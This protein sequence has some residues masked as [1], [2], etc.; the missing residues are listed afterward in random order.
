MAAAH[1]VTWWHGEGKRLI[2]PE[3]IWDQPQRNHTDLSTT[4][5]RRKSDQ[6]H[7]ATPRLRRFT[8]QIS[9]SPSAVR[10]VGLSGTYHGTCLCRT[11]TFEKLF[12]NFCRYLPDGFRKFEK[13]EVRNL[14]PSVRFLEI[15]ANNI[16][17]R[18]GL[19]YSAPP[20]SRSLEATSHC[21]A[22]RM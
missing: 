22:L 7:R 9:F 12:T 3:K 15:M 14:K 16:I 17:H 4:H 6:S 11:E 2:P 19:G 13:I 8:L 5:E 1:A 10:V 21:K 18:G 20:C